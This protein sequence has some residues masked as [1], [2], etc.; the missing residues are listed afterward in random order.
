MN[1]GL[2]RILAVSNCS[3]T[4]GPHASASTDNV[5][6]VRLSESLTIK[7]ITSG[8]IGLET[9]GSVWHA[10]LRA[11]IVAKFVLKRNITGVNN[12]TYHLCIRICSGE[13]LGRQFSSGAR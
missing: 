11:F 4:T 8:E 10:G 2:P 5:H 1:I 9:G 3:D 13:P 7:I 12:V 6:D